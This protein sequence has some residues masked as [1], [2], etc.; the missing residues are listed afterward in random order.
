MRERLALVESQLGATTVT[1]LE[2]YDID[3]VMAEIISSDLPFERWYRG[4][5]EDLHGVYLGRYE[6]FTLPTRA[7]QPQDLL[8]EWRLP[9]G[10]AAVDSFQ[11]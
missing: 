4:R 10:R 7:S 3:L 9:G 6:Q 8:F 5:F 2:A 11:H 1:T